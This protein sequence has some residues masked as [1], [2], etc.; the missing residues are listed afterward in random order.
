MITFSNRN[1]S[2]NFY[3][4]ETQTHNFIVYLCFFILI[5]IILV[6]KYTKLGNNVIYIS[7]M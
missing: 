4:Y 6:A 5:G 1:I 3:D 2:G 7:N